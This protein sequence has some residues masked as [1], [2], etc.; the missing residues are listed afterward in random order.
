MKKRLVAVVLAGLLGLGGVA[1]G[2][3]MSQH[4]RQGLEETAETI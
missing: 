1:F 3:A 4:G 2:L